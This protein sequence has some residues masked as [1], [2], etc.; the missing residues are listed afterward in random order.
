MYGLVNKAIEGL[1]R[2]QAGEEIWERIKAKAGVEEEF[3]VGMNPYPDEVTYKLVGAA[4]EVLGLSADEI[5][6]E[7]GE[8]WILYTAQEGY[9]HL[10]T[11][12][13]RDFKEF[14]YNLDKLHAH[15][16]ANFPS[17]Q[18][19]SFRCTETSDNELVLHYY[20]GRPGLA[21]MVIGLL[22]GLGRMLNTEVAVTH[23]ASRA[24]GADH[25][26]F[27]VRYHARISS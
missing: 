15:V 23:T 1:I 8:Y 26:E 25:D 16:G 4:S 27:L 5:L 13:G 14:L 10:L 21:P 12:S 11:M 3:F 9:G 19:P 20:S 24:R 2:Q 7:F 18:P 6:R 22:N 17:L